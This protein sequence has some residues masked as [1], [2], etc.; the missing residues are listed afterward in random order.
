VTVRAWRRRERCGGGGSMRWWRVGHDGAEEARARWHG[1]GS[2]AG[3]E[4][5]VAIN[6][7]EATC[8]G[9]RRGRD[10]SFIHTAFGTG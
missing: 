2:G 5:E 6:E 8:G 3:T 7:E 1:E 10:T 9:G 4:E